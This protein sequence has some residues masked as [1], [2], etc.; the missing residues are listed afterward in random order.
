MLDDRG[1]TGFIDWGYAGVA[2]RYQDLALAVRSI[3]W[4]LGAEWVPSF[5][6]AYRLPDGLDAA[7]IEFF[8]LLD[9]FF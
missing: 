5:L 9:E 1:V 8:H 2:D 6:D 7:K 4:N 3:T